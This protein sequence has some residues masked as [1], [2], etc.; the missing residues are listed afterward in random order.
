MWLGSPAHRA[1]LLNPA[2][3]EQAVSLRVASTFQGEVG[4]HVWTSQFGDLGSEAAAR[5]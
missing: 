4:A 1:N 5:R 3:T 2:W